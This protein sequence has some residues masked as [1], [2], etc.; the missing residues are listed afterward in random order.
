[1][2]PA[3]PYTPRRHPE[4]PVRKRAMVRYSRRGYVL[5][6]YFV[7]TLYTKQGHPVKLGVPGVSDLIGYR[8]HTVTADDVGRTLPVFTAVEVKQGHGRTSAEQRRFLDA[9]AA[10]GGEAWVTTNDQDEL[11]TGSTGDEA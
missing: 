6:R 11:W 4:P 2:S 10:A 1:M 7:G 8:V 3:R 5:F 9:V